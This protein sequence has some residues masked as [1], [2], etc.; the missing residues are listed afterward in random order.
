MARLEKK[1]KKIEEFAAQNL[2]RLAVGSFQVWW[3]KKGKEI[4][5]PIEESESTEEKKAQIRE[6]VENRRRLIEGRKEKNNVTKRIT[7]K[8]DEKCFDLRRYLLR[9]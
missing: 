1:T 4:S 8:K 6:K 7:H 5:F 2:R 9:N 3:I